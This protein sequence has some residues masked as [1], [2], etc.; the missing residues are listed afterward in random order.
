[1]RKRGLGVKL[2]IRPVSQALPHFEVIQVEH[3]V[4]LHLLGVDWDETKVAAEQRL[5]Q[6]AVEIDSSAADWFDLKYTILQRLRFRLICIGTCQTMKP[7]SFIALSYCCPDET[8]SKSSV[9]SGHS[10]KHF[11]LSGHMSNA[12]I[13]ELWPGEGMWIDSLCIEQ[14]DE[15]EKAVAIAAMDLVYRNARAIIVAL[16]DIEQDSNMSS[17]IQEI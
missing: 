7:Q 1:M 5:L 6:K 4:M 8:W 9:C 16:E 13:D 11:Q 14:E 3:N 17:A 12:L 15:K 10:S 2:Q